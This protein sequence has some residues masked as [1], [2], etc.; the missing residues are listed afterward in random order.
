MNACF[1]KAV[2]LVGSE[3]LEVVDSVVNCWWPARILVKKALENRRN[4]D[5]SQNI[6]LLDKA[7]PWKGHL[8]ELEREEQC[9]R[10]VYPLPL[11]APNYNFSHLL[12][13]V[14]FVVH[15]SPENIWI[16]QCANTNFSAS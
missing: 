12:P 6:I 13:K 11:R 5:D 15:P 4:V 1:E 8:I 7:C 14:L 10:V 2:D 3:F 9:N 16:V